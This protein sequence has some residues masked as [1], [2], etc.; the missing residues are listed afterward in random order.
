MGGAKRMLED[1]E[2]KRQIALEIAMTAGALATCEL[3]DCAIN[4]DDDP[5]PA[6]K[7][8]NALISQSDPLVAN[9]YGNRRELS[10]YIKE[11]IEDTN[12]ECVRCAEML[13]R[14]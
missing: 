14:D 4:R 5:T 3:H 2:D 8:G 9:F 1:A 10:D 13:M 12:D 7:L 6:Y 11:V